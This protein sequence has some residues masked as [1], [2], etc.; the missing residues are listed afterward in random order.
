MQRRLVRGAGLL[1]ENRLDAGGV[2]ENRGCA[3]PLC[4][5]S[6]KPDSGEGA[7]GVLC[8]QFGFKPPEPVA[9]IPMH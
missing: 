9:G 1:G 2:A 3:D 5:H 4:P 8:A 6:G 7:E